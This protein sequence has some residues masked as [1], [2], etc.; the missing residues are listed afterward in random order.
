[1]FGAFKPTGSKS[2]RHASSSFS[3]HHKS[4]HSHRHTNPNCSSTSTVTHVS[5]FFSPASTTSFLFIVNELQINLEPNRAAGSDP[6]VPRDQWTNTM[7]PQ[8]ATAYTSETIGTVFRYTNGIITPAQ[9]YAW[10]RP[11]WNRTPGRIVR[12]DPNTNTINGYPIPYD[13]QWGPST[14]T[15]FSCSP[16]LPIIVSE[17]D[18]TLGTAFMR[19][20]CPCDRHYEGNYIP[21]NVLHFEPGGEGSSCPGVSFVNATAAGYTFVMGKDPS[22]MPSLVPMSY[23]N[24]R[25]GEIPESRG[26]SGQLPTVIGLMAFQGQPEHVDNVFLNGKWHENRWTGTSHAPRHVPKGGD[27]RPRGFLVQVCLDNLQGNMPDHE[28]NN[29]PTEVCMAN[30]ERLEWRDALVRD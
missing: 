29:L 2:N 25:S 16:H 8:L 30:L 3:S 7:P 11:V 10:Y 15:I 28:E 27:E 1:M 9:N 24:S 13:N 5:S 6:S 20:Y 21:W 22:W 23:R 4:S 14:Q 12:L 17:T 26:L 19:R 18:A